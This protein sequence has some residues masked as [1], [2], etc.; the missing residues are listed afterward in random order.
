MRFIAVFL[1]GGLLAFYVTEVLS[2]IFKKIHPN[3]LNFNIHHSI[4]GPV[5][6][7]AGITSL[8]WGQIILGSPN[9]LLLAI[10][11]FGAGLGIIFHHLLV[12]SFIFSEK[13]EKD[14]IAKHDK[15]IERLLEIFPGGLTWIALT[16]PIWLSFTLPY[17]VAYLIIIADIYWFITAM[18]IAILIF[19]GW[20][21]MDFANKQDWLKKIKQDFPAGWEKYSHFFVLPTYKEGLE[22]LKPAFDAIV[23]ADYPKD[24]IFI[25]VGLEER[26]DPEKITAVQKYWQENARKIGGAF[27]TVHP[28]GL[29]GELAG[30]ATNRNFIVNNAAAEFKKRGINVE[31]VFVT[32]LD[33][34]FVIH[35]EFPAGALHK[36]LSTPKNIRDKRSFTGAF[37]YNNNYWQAPTPM[38]VLA[39]GTA[40]WQLSEM[41]GSD[42]YINFSSL[43]INMRS[44][45]NI[46][47]WIPNKINDDSGFFWKAYY[48]YKGDYKV[49]PHF[50]LISAD[51]CL[52]I[53]LWKTFKNQYLQLKRWAYGVEHMPFIIRQYFSNKDLNFWDK[54]DKLFFIT[55]SYFKW[56]TLALFVTFAGLFIPLI[57]PGF[58]Q[59]AVAYNLPVLSS[60]IL[61]GAFLSL[62]STYFV[63]EKTV[64]PRPRNWSF[65]KRLWSYLQWILVPI[66]LVTITS[67]PAID[68]QTTLM[69]GKYMEFRVTNKARLS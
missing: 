4:L 17:A 3:P 46:G 43:S 12:E 59:S 10:L 19:I 16:S 60:W 6:F 18:R 35:H 49:I 26:D 52:D 29:P 31:N 23:N 8:L 54:T 9:N 48:F 34:D 11:L 22:V 39:A 30:P 53:S 42:K 61:T 65:L 47:L 1:V 44:L 27:V 37:L 55:W 69:L 7:L 58:S 13:A 38:R 56:G 68:A 41:V 28:Y 63:H 33:A 67:I 64:P 62:F 21:K 50:M 24:K 40:F 32:T 20:R 66:V 25:G 15:G 45:L 2:Q 51:A 36:Y 14:F 57:N 5:L